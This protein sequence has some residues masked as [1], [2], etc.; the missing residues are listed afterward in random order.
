MA[1]LRKKTGIFVEMKSI[2]WVVLFALAIRTFIVEL[3]FIPSGSMKTTL[4]EGD[5]ILTTKYSYGF[6]R[7]S[8]P[9]SLNLFSDR[10]FFSPPSRGDI[11]VM[12]PPNDMSVR[13]VKRL[14]GLPNDKIE[15][16][17]GILYINGNM[18]PK[19]MVGTYVDKTGRSYISYKETL[20]NGVS[21]SV[22][23][24]KYITRKDYN[25]GPYIVPKGCYFFLGD[26]RDE[27]NDS[28]KDLGFVPEQNLIA[29]AHYILF[30]TERVLYDSDLGVIDN[31]L[32][33]WSWLKSI[34][35]NRLFSNLYAN[36]S[37][38]Y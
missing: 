1:V 3:F 35:F 2:L 15:I 6:S 7:Y 21:Y 38:H 29:K 8:F 26:N 5:Y 12:R 23:Q 9:F 33:V 18:V 37:E 27:S 25:F 20:P 24:L 22:A 14:I 36:N 16:V 28:R 30:S 17:K 34:R 4:L 10:I 19:E 31:I 13:Y 11:I 32:N